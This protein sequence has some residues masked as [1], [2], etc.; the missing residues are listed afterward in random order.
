MEL[1]GSLYEY[2]RSFINL[3]EN[4]LIYV[5]NDIQN[6]LYHLDVKKYLSGL[7]HFEQN[8]DKLKHYIV[9]EL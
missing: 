9:Y 6:A 4:Y 1:I 8:F 3:V 5:Q 7:N 2:F